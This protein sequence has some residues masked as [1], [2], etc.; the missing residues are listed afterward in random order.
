MGTSRIIDIGGRAVIIEFDRKRVKNINVR[1]RSDGTLYCSMPY[2]VSFAEAEKFIQSKS[3]FFIKALD[4][5]SQRHEEEDD[6]KTIDKEAV[7]KLK[8]LIL[9]LIE[10]HMP[11]F[12]AR[13]VARPSRIV[14]GN[15][16][17]FWGECMKKRG[18]V[19]FSTRLAVKDREL[20]EYVVVHELAHFLVPNHSEAFWNVVAGVLPDYKTR[21]K[22]L[23]GKAVKR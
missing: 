8:D 22:I 14:I 15:Y 3:K 9:E 21:R 19:K 10:L 13:G 1:V 17:S 2:W 23:N 18:I 20:V 7:E 4:E 12:A 6:L 11:Y 5:V 16:R